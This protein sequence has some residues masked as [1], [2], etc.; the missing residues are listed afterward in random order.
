MTP[1]WRAARVHEP[2]SE[3]LRHNK[4][5]TLGMAKAE[6]EKVFAPE[7]TVLSDDKQQHL[8]DAMHAIS[9]WSFWESLR[10]ELGLGMSQ[11]QELVRTTLTAV[12]AD[13]GFS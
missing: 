1:S 4:V 13:A 6:V 7:L 8:L 2:T 3:Q 12:L 11:A 10:T 9:I 5:Q